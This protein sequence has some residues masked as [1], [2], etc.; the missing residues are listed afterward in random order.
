MI[1]WLCCGCGG[2]LSSVATADSATHKVRWR[3]QKEERLTDLV[4]AQTCLLTLSSWFSPGGEW[5]G[6][7][8]G[9][10]FL[11][12]ASSSSENRCLATATAAALL[13]LLPKRERTWMKYC[14]WRGES[15]L[16]SLAEVMWLANEDVVGD[17]FPLPSPFVSFYAAKLVLSLTRFSGRRRRCLLHLLFPFPAVDNLNTHLPVL[18]LTLATIAIIIHERMRLAFYALRTCFVLQKMVFWGGVHLFFYLLLIQLMPLSLFI[19]P[20]SCLRFFIFLISFCMHDLNFHKFVHLRFVPQDPEESSE[21]FIIII[22][23]MHFK[24]K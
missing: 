19:T 16:T 9:I 22:W 15:P 2:G 5:R 6:R 8:R 17:W 21:C 20:L 4:G 12:Y 14:W 7:R 11:E 23:F 10:V 18:S 3:R 13:L 1:A 24:K